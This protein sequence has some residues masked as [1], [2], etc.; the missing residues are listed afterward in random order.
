LL[1][2][3]LVA[4]VVFFAN[5]ISQNT[6]IACFK[7]VIYYLSAERLISSGGRIFTV[8]RSTLQ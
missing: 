3:L 8:I 7:F 1:Q 5:H 6:T 2:L 4:I